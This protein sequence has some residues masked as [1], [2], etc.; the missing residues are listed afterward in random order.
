MCTTNPVMVVKFGL[1]SFLLISPFLLHI[2]KP[3]HISHSTE[4]SQVELKNSL[5]SPNE[6]ARDWAL[7]GSGTYYHS[8]AAYYLFF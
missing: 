8:G 6:Q 1:L 5:N 7:G 3:T 4:C 2:H